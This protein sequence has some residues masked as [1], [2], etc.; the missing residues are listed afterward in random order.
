MKSRLQDQTKEKKLS[1]RRFCSSSV[2]QSESESERERRRKA[3][4]I[5]EPCQR[6]EKAL[7][8]VGDVDNNCCW[9]P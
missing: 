8:H 7:E 2:L 6:N 4:Q 3:K 5:L 9:R 1:S